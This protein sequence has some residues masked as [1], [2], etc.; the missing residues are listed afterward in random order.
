MFPEPVRG[1][2]VGSRT[3]SWGRLDRGEISE[4]EHKTK[5]LKK[6]LDHSAVLKHFHR[7]SGG[8]MC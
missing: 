2:S 8:I 4:D 5:L 1:L 7:M 3:H 6:L